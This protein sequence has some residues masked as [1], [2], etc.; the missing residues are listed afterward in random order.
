MESLP[1]VTAEEGPQITVPKESA[2]Q[3]DSGCKAL[4]M[5]W[6]HAG[7]R[8]FVRI[9]WHVCIELMSWTVGQGPK[10]KVFRHVYNSISKKRLIY[11]S[12]YI[13][14]DAC[15]GEYIKPTALPIHEMSYGAY[16]KIEIWTG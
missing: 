9:Y 11:L 10:S 6:G 3:R 16:S 4:G 2:L 12:T 14:E 13:Y 5:I 7:D 1:R 15:V 8:T